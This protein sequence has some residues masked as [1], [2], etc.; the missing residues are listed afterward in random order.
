VRTTEGNLWAL[1]ATISE[2]KRIKLEDSLSHEP[3]FDTVEE[4]PAHPPRIEEARASSTWYRGPAFRFPGSLRAESC[5][6]EL[7]TDP[8]STRP[9]PELA[10]I[11]DA[12]PAEYPLAVVRGEDGQVVSVC[13]S[14]RST[15]RGAEAGVE[16]TPEYRGRGYAG[17]AVAVW[18]RAVLAEGR[19]P[20]YSTQWTNAASRAVARKLGLIMYGEDCHD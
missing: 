2:E 18:A 4:M 14:A 3:T 13:H 17:A 1:S 9:V 20:L 15:S 19:L 7:L 16:T 6:S 8:L 12:S 5:V 10:W 11:K